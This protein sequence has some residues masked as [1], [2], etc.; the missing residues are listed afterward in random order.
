MSQLCSGA[1]LEIQDKEGVTPLMLAAIKK[2]ERTFDA[3][4]KTEVGIRLVKQTLLNPAQGQPQRAGRQSTA[5]PEHL[6]V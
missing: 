2:R 3:M 1:R 6:E 4:V 5:G